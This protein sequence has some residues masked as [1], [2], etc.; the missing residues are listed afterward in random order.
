MLR[1]FVDDLPAII[2]GRTFAI[3]FLVFAILLV[4]YLRYGGG[5]ALNGEGIAFLPFGSP[6]ELVSIIDA[7]LSRIAINADGRLFGIV[8]PKFQRADLKVVELVRGQLEPFPNQDWQRVGF[9]RPTAITVDSRGL[10]WIAESDPLGRHDPR[11]IAVD[12]QAN[13]PLL[14]HNFDRRL[15]PV[16]SD[17]RD[18]AVSPDGTHIVVADS[19][20]LR[21]SPRLVH[22]DL[23]TGN[24]TAKLIAHSS[25]RARRVAPVV[26]G[27][28]FGLP[29]GLVVHREGVNAVALDAGG[30]RLVYAAGANDGLFE[31]ET[32]L[33]WQ[34]GQTQTA[35]SARIRKLG[36]KPWTE[37]I[38]VDLAGNV[39]VADAEG[40]AILRYTPSGSVSRLVPPGTFLWPSALSFGPD[41]G[42]YVAESALNQPR[43]RIQLA[44]VLREAPF[45]LLDPVAGW[46][47]AGYGGVNQLGIY[48]LDVGMSGVLG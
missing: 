42:L 13:Q 21:L 8:H 40:G 18:I 20:A 15:L 48:R 25:T 29:L 27:V 37:A 35:P 12:P 23:S 22:Y 16:G 32:Q 43:W 38:A 24:V 26:D 30:E 7:P 9:T 44:D 28:R 2:F 47:Q 6:P 10:V 33:F 14:T 34:Q 17:I 46:I 19:S 1:W 41:G 39:F 11:L 4:S 5:R 31:V 45:G 3:L 36:D